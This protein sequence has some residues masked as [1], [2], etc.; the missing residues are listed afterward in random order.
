MTDIVEAAA[1]IIA[2]FRSRMQETQSLTLAESVARLR[3]KLFA[4]GADL[5]SIRKLAA[6]PRIAGFTTNP[7]LM[8]KAGISDYAAFGRAALQLTGDRPISFEVFADEPR[9][10]GAASADHRGLGPQR[11]RE[12]S[13]DHHDRCA[14]R[15]R[16]PRAQCRRHSTNVTALTHGPRK[17]TPSPFAAGTLRA[18]VSV[19]AG[20]IAE[21][22][23]DP[24]RSCAPPSTMLE[25]VP[26]VER[27]GPARASRPN[28]FQADAAGR[29]HHH[30]NPRRPGESRIAS[31]RT[32]T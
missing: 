8:R 20:R 21:H 6:D 10:I 25:R 15:S 27:S 26:N 12:D 23:P 11:V 32:W 16:G 19:F 28:V 29:A 31:A 18:V 9:E 5:D 4:D 13:G 24:C 3:I 7:T 30:G 22:G 14:D 1:W 17:S 2:D